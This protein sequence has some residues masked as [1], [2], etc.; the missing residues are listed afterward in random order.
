MY[1]SQSDGTHHLPFSHSITFYIP[2]VTSALVWG[3][4]Q[5]AGGWCLVYESRSPYFTSFE[6]VHVEKADEMQHI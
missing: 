3:T 5:N 4:L 2:N 1:D 6:A